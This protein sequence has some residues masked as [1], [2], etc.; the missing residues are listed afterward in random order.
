MAFW[1]AARGRLIPQ[2]TSRNRRERAECEAHRAQEPQCTSAYMRIP[3][4]EQRSNRLAQQVSKG[5]P[6]VGGLICGRIATR[7]ALARAPADPVPRTHAEG[8]KLAFE[9]PGMKVGIAEYDDG[10]TPTTVFHF[11]DSATGAFSSTRAGPI[12]W[13]PRNMDGSCSTHRRAT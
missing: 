3:S 11:P 8:R 2:G 6:Q 1:N 12:A 9:F 5:S 4:T 13:P 7:F 10:P